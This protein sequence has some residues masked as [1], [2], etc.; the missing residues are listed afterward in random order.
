MLLHY[1]SFSE[2]S[3]ESR[4]S[5]KAGFSMVTNL[6]KPL[7]SE[8]TY[9]CSCHMDKDHIRCS[10]SGN[11]QDGQLQCRKSTVCSPETCYKCDLRS[12]EITIC[13]DGVLK[14]DRGNMRS[15]FTCNETGCP[16]NSESRKTGRYHKNTTATLNL[17]SQQILISASFLGLLT[18]KMIALN[19]VSLQPKN[20]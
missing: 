17:N 9:N 11:N 16:Q 3:S 12:T 2:A 7:L 19:F 15:T 10:S 5:L 20:N 4:C 6:L 13:C 18:Q 8:G 1:N 14:I